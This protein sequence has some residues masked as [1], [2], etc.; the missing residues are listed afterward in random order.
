MLRITRVDGAGPV[1]ALKLEGKLVGPWVDA[2]REECEPGRALCLDLSAVAFVDAEGVTLLR[3]LLA[4]G[5]TL[6]PCSAL[7][8]ELLNVEAQ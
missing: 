6:A 7:V 8:A 1:E 2:L 4:Q 3:E 5:A